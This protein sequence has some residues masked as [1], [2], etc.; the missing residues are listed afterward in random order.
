MKRW[1]WVVLFALGGL[2]IVS[3]GLGDLA[4]AYMPEDAAGYKLASIGFFAAAVLWVAACALRITNE[5]RAE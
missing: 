2:C 1:E 4:R 5:E 3:A